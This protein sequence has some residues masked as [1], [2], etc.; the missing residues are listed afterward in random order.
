MFV[1]MK[2]ISFIRSVTTDYELA[3]DESA[4]KFGLFRHFRIDV[5]STSTF[6]ITAT[7]N[8]VPPATTDPAPT[9]PDEIRDRSDPD[10][11][12]HRSG[13]WFAFS[14]STSGDDDTEVFATPSLTAG[15][16]I[17]RLQDWRFVDE[18]SSSD[19][20]TQTCFDVSM[21]P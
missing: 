21:T 10:L 2:I 14:S 3:F 13:Q 17:L 19:Y 7:A 1:S 8:P 16:Y 4:N 6:T 18:D 9:P 20:P 5:A 15:S 11:F 12:L